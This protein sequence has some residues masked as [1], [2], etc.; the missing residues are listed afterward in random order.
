[1]SWRYLSAICAGVTVAVL[2]R[3][4]SDEFKAWTPKITRW[5]LAYAVSRLPEQLRD[6][7]QEEWASHLA[8]VPGDLGK[9]VEAAGFVWTA[10]AAA[11]TKFGP[12]QFRYVVRFSATP[13][14]RCVGVL[15]GIWYFEIARQE[16]GPVPQLVRATVESLAAEQLSFGDIFDLRLGLLMDCMNR[17]RGKESMRWAEE[18]GR[19]AHRAGMK[20]LEAQRRVRSGT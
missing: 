19:K 10:R 3:L 11:S 9:L 17:L 4:T 13:E 2:G 16:D 8:D 7:Y 1:M 12:Y 18:L 5:V 6:R 20:V 15:A 14:R